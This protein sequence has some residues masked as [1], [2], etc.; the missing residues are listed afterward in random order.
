MTGEEKHT[1]VMV[2]LAKINTTL[3]E[4]V[5]PAVDQVY[6]NKED[7]IVI[8]TNAKNNK[9]N[10]SRLIAYISMAISFIA[11]T[12]LGFKHFK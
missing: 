4:V 1:Q 3:K 6:E 8:K 10:R 2:A 5:K 12:I 9:D 11:V 7:I